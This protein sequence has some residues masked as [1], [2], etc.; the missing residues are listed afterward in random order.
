MAVLIIGGTNGLGLE[1]ARQKEREGQNVVVVGEHKPKADGIDFVKLDLSH[2]KLAKRI[3]SIVAKLPQIDELI[4]AAGYYE[5]GTITHLTEDD[6][7]RMISHGGRGL[8]YFTKYLISKQHQLKTLVTITSS[9]QWTPRRLEPVYG[10]VMAGEAMFSSAMSHDDR[11]ERVL[12]AA[13]SGLQI[14]SDEDPNQRN[15][16]ADM[17][18][19]VWIA[20]SIVRLSRDEFRY[21]VVRLERNPQ[22]IQVVESR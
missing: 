17:L 21:R 6:I 14:R 15:M 9:A 3:K 11:I 5:E 8:I 16:L 2:T 22:T 4:Y 18:D 20:A 10:F 12:V 19:P 1:I 7:E 13:P